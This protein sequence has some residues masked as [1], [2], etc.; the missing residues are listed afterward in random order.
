[1]NF[2]TFQGTLEDCLDLQYS[3]SQ[4]LLLKDKDVHLCL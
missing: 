2:V 1:M 3:T 4:A